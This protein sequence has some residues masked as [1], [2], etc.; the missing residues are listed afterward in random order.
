MK[1]KTDQLVC[2]DKKGG[3]YA[4]FEVP[5]HR[6]TF[7]RFA[8]TLVSGLEVRPGVMLDRRWSRKEA[9]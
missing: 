4:A 5:Y 3:T 6:W 7:V 2:Y 1:R 8:T 9:R